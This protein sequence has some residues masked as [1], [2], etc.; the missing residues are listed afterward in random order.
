MYNMG[1]NIFSNE[2]HNLAQNF[3][4]EEEKLIT[5]IAGLNVTRK[6]S[7]WNDKVLTSH[8]ETS[9]FRSFFDESYIP[10]NKQTYTDDAGECRFVP[11][12]T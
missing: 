7:R 2:T 1:T 5:S 9:R 10:V 6:R 12:E 11:S 3:P 4:S 8:Q